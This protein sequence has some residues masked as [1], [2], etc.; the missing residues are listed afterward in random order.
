M[1]RTYSLKKDGNKK[2]SAHFKV[3]EFR[4]K[5]GT[6]KI[7]IDDNLLLVLES[8][9]VN[10]NCKAININSGYRTSE[11]SVHVGGYAT[12]NHTKGIAC[13]IKCKKHN[14]G[15]YTA[16]D[17]L[18]CYEIMGYKG[19]AGKINDFS[20]HIDTRPTKCFFI[21]GVN[22]T[23]INS[24]CNYYGRKDKE[25]Y[26]PVE[27]VDT[28]LNIRKGAGK[29]YTAVGNLLKGSH[30]AIYKPTVKGKIFTV[31]SW[32]QVYN[33]KQWCATSNYMVAGL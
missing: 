6:D 21:E 30:I 3:K 25:Q 4:C 10:L 23:V 8:L 33:T 9:F 32:G 5:D 1:I 27:V 11:W 15:Y 31:G 19:G 17:I 2:I 12:D 14:G 24:W 7:L 16:K 18:C 29:Q 13:D 28:D 20:V 26:I 22:T